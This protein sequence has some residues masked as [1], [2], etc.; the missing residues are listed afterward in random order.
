MYHMHTMFDVR[1]GIS[2]D[3]FTAAFERF[4]VALT[5]DGLLHAAGSIGRRHV[6]P[7]LD[8]DRERGQGYFVTMTFRDLAQADAAHAALKSR[9]EP[10]N[11]I[12]HGVYS[13]VRNQIFTCWDDC[14]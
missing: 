9:A 2:Q 3:E 5:D 12:H 8:T 1:P 4:S 13:R 7:K 6:N 11:T 10:L 14:A